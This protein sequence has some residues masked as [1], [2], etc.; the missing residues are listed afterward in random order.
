MIMEDVRGLFAPEAVRG[1]FG[2]IRRWVA[3]AEVG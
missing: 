3:G 1:P 2:L